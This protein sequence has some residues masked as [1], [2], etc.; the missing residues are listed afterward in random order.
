MHYVLKLNQHQ[1]SDARGILA[2]IQIL[3][4]TCIA[5]SLTQHIDPFQVT[6]IKRA[7]VY[8]KSDR[9]AAE[10]V[11]KAKHIAYRHMYIA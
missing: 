5:V 7:D 9:K 6:P 11:I 10:L 1:Q 3:L 8:M 2:V 4:Q